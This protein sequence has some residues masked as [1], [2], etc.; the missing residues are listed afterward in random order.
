MKKIFEKNLEIQKKVKWEE[1]FDIWRKG[2]ENL[3]HWKKLLTQFDVTWFEWRSFFV[4][5]LHCDN[6][7]WAIYDIQNPLEVISQF[8]GGPFSSWKKKFYGRKN[9][10]SFEEIVKN[11]NMQNYLPVKRLA[12]NFP[13]ETTLIGYIVDGEVYILEG[14]HR[15]AA[16]A[17]L[18]TKKMMITGKVFIALAKAKKSDIKEYI[19][20]QD[21]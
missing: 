16:L 20:F 12:A 11:R 15:C 4:E 1:V 8:R 9:F 17:M 19:R 10:P 2:E 3:T 13:D 14:M 5:K 18:F 6:K 7:E 21:K